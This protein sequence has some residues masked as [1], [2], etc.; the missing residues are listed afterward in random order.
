[1]SDDFYAAY[2]WPTPTVFED[3]GPAQV[4]TGLVDSRGNTI[5]KVNPNR[6]P[7]IGFHRPSSLAQQR[8]YTTK[9]RSCQ[10]REQ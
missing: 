2:N 10:E 9:A 1:M 3:Y 6:K 7:P 8:D 4:D 5:T